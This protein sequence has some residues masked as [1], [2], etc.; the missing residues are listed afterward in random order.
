MNWKEALEHVQRMN[1]QSYLGYS[2]WRLQMRRSYN[3]LW[4]TRDHPM[5]ATPQSVVLR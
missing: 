1:E 5:P 4:I 3:Q 2:D